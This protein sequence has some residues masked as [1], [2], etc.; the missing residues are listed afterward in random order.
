MFTIQY[1]TVYFTAIYRIAT[2]KCCISVMWYSTVNFTAHHCTNYCNIPYYKLPYFSRYSTVYID[3]GKIDYFRN[4]VFYSRFHR[5]L[6]YTHG[7][8]L[9]FVKQHYTVHFT[10]DYYEHGKYLKITYMYLQLL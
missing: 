1:F 6:P 5:H 2:V 10:A 4:A 9:Y 8:K 7:E 3:Y